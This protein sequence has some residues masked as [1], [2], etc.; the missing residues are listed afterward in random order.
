GNA[1]G[2]A[3]TR[4]MNSTESDHAMSRTRSAF[5]ARLC[6]GIA[7]VVTLLLLTASGAAARDDGDGM[8]GT[9]P[10]GVE[11]PDS[12]VGNGRA[13][14]LSAADR[15]FVVRVRLAGL[16]EMPAGMMAVS[17]GAD[18]RVREVG[19]EIAAQHVVLDRPTRDAAA[20]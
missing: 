19:R 9:G 6:A 3:P 10:G 12:P 7:A 2:D 16:W 4:P 13:A 17:K 1:A 14:P 5:A 18:P 15:D 11:V 8:G 20:P